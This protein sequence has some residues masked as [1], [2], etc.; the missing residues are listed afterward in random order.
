MQLMVIEFTIKM[1][2]IGFIQFFLL[3]HID[4]KIP[5]DDTTVSKYVGAW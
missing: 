1:F 4:Y 5:E 2:H 3:Y